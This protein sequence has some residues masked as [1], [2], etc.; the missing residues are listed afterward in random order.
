MG[1][2][3]CARVHGTGNV[4]VHEPGN[5]SAADC[6]IDR[7]AQHWGP[8]ICKQM[9]LFCVCSYDHAWSYKRVLVKGRSHTV[10]ERASRRT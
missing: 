6:G 4:C 3:W 8:T 1:D 2:G 10:K 7:D 5:A 9:M